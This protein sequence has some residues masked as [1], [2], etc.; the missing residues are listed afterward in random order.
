ML[1]R[2]F[3]KQNKIIKEK[4][5]RKKKK[6]KKIDRQITPCEAAERPYDT[7]LGAKI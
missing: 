3:F 4:K 7:A 6:K 5:K 2:A 1:G